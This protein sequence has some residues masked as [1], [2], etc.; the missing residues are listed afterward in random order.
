ML[1]LRK[2]YNKPLCS[3]SDNSCMFIPSLSKCLRYIEF[4]LAPVSGINLDPILF[5]CF[6]SIYDY[7]VHYILVL[8]KP[9]I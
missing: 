1:Y 2:E 7:L 8:C 6:D 3:D 5:T 4:T 9:S